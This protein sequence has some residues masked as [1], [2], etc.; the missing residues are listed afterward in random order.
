MRTRSNRRSRALD[1]TIQSKA[2]ILFKKA[3]EDGS[4]LS[5]KVEEKIEQGF[6]QFVVDG[7]RWGKKKPGFKK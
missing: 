2:E 6:Q 5:K 4:S 3:F 1:Q 7:I